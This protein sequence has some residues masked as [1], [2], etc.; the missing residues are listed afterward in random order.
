MH[1]LVTLM[2]LGAPVGGLSDAELATALRGEVPVRSEAFTNAAGKAAGRGVG[3]I[4]IER[5]IA[6]VWASVSHYDD[7]AEYQPRVEK[8][9]V[10]ERRP[11]LLRVR[12][13]V[14]ASITTARYTGWYALDDKA[15]TVRWRLDTEAEG[16]T[17]SDMDGG[18]TMHELGPSRTLLVYRTYVDA[19]R[20]VPRFVQ[21][22]MARRS[23]PDL[24]RSIKRRIESGGTWRKG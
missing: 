6:E 3:A 5:P 9:E 21:D 23:I 14:N 1:L 17:I 12:M 8:V 18:Y 2:A 15:R 10:L 7:K 24:L 13:T 16:N 22:F 11:G 4:V 19:G 20:A